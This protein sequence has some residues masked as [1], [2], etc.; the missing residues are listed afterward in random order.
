M[1]KKTWSARISE[2]EKSH[3]KVTK[4]VK[5]EHWNLRIDAET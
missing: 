3:L 4:E 5:F 2:D 1:T